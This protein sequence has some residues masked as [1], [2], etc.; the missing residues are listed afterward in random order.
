MW[1]TE[2]R[3]WRLGRVWWGWW[4]GSLWW[5]STNDPALPHCFYF[6]C[7]A[8]FSNI[9]TET[10]VRPSPSWNVSPVHAPWSF[11]VNAATKPLS[12]EKQH[13]DH[14]AMLKAWSLQIRPLTLTFLVVSRR[15]LCIQ[16]PVQVW[17]PHC[18]RWWWCPSAR[19]FWILLPPRRHQLRGR[20]QG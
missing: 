15:T 11:S 9:Q 10:W 16:P 8:G 2:P 4:R 6:S 14:V 18:W 19:P 17:P 5:W 1:R 7:P 20:S 13:A 12:S 3:V